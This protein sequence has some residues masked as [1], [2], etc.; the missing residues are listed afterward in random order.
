MKLRLLALSTDQAQFEMGHL[1]LIS[2]ASNFA[3]HQG[4]NID[5]STLFLRLSISF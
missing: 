2:Q 4:L 3:L 5:M 1:F